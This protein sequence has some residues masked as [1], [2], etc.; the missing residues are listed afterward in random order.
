MTSLVLSG[1]Q[2]AS[3]GHGDPEGC[4]YRVAWS[5]NPH[6]R[7]GAVDTA[8]AVRQHASFVRAL[9]QCGAHIE[10]IAFVHGAFVSVFAKD[11][12]MDR[13]IKSG[14]ASSEPK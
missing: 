11:C 6:M 9:R 3:E 4:A 1:P 14:S 5:I 10:V 7:V 12:A 13:Q 2:C 8:R